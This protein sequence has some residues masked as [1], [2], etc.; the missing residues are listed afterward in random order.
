M[1]GVDAGTPI[2]SWIIVYEV[3]GEVVENIEEAGL[4]DVR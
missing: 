1:E 2:I 3:I 4:V